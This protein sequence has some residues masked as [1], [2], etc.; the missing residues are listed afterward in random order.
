VFL[1]RLH[2]SCLQKL[3]S[4]SDAASIATYKILPKHHYFCHLIQWIEA[5][6]L[7]FTCHLGVV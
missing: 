5:A 1:C 2:L 7:G 3:A 6:L 4:D